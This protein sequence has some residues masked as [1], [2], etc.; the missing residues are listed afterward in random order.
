MCS[1]RA[2][3]D[4]FLGRSVGVY[5]VRRDPTAGDELV[6]WCLSEYNHGGRC[7]IGIET[8]EATAAGG[9]RLHGGALLVPTVAG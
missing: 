8:A 9:W 1:E 3:V 7:E 4:E 6:S 2:S 5:I